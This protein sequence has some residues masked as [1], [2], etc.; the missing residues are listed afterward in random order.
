MWV[1]PMIGTDQ[2][3]SALK[4]LEHFKSILTLHINLNVVKGAYVAPNAF[5]M[6]ETLKKM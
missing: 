4:K 5:L 2:R 6:M 3:Y 1:N